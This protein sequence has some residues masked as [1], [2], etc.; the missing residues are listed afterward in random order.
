MKFTA[1]KIDAHKMLLEIEVPQPEVA[2]AVDK[3]YHKLAAKVNIPG[4]RKGK[5]PR[6]IMEMR[7]GKQALLD[8][9]FELLASPAYMQALEEQDV[10]PVTR[11]EIEVVTFEEDKPLVFKVRFVVKPVIELGEYKGLKVAKPA[12]TVSEEEVDKQIESLRNRHAK[13]V[14]AE[15]AALDKGDFAIID[16][17]GFIDGVPFKGGEGKGYPLEIGS[18]SFI[19]GFEDQL[20][21]AKAGDEREVKVQFPEEYMAPELAGKAAEF[22][23]KVIDVKRREV[24]EVDAEF[25]KEVSDFDSVEEL[26]ADIENNLKKTAENKADREFRTNAI[27]AA[28]DNC[29]VDLPEEVVQNEID[30]MLRE[31]DVNLQNRGMS[32]AKYMEA[33]KTDF[34]MLRANY[35][36]SAVE[37]V[38]TD[39]MLEAIAKAENIEANSEDL[40]KEIA[41]MAASYRAPVEEVRRII[42]SEGRLEA[43]TRTVIRKKA[44]QVIIDAAEATEAAEA[45]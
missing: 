8:E 21:G 3:A 32:L 28:V 22:K 33:T 23:V 37:S 29:T 1:E 40:E 44:A 45:V 6:K 36:E 30:S 9:A 34:A 13:M 18:G 35:R 20:M 26:K 19:P 42:L 17:E 38:K 15:G 10:E 27:K 11:P 31:M 25:V 41:G 14:V 39:L 43:L 5:V 7:L 16:F 24:P 12:A 2:K 4:F